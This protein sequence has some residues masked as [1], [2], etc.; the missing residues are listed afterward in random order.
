MR[1]GTCLR[2]AMGLEGWCSVRY[3]AGVEIVRGVKGGPKCPSSV[4]KGAGVI[5]WLKDGGWGPT[6]L[7]R[8]Q[9]QYWQKATSMGRTREMDAGDE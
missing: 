2:R 6:P 5:A 1:L 7:K 3:I 8:A 4:A 9:G